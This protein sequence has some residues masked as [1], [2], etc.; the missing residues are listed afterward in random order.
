MIQIMTQLPDWLAN[1]HI[2]CLYKFSLISF[3][4]VSS[5]NEQKT[6]RE[7]KYDSH[8]FNILNTL[9][10]YPNIYKYFRDYNIGLRL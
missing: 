4:K 10:I 2:E 9:N 3:S 8:D 5:E 1:M 7:G 6:S